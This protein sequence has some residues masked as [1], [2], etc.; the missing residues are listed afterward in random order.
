MASNI[1]EEAPEPPAGQRIEGWL[2]VWGEYFGGLTISA[3]IR[4]E[5]AC[6]LSNIDTMNGNDAGVELGAC[7]DLLWLLKAENVM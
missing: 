1:E 4:M 6:K 2:N 3:W 5:A 7:Y